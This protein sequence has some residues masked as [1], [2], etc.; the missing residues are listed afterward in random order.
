MIKI[1]HNVRNKNDEYTRCYTEIIHIDRLRD[2]TYTV[3]EQGRAFL[4]IT[5]IDGYTFRYMPVTFEQLT[6]VVITSDLLATN[7]VIFH[8]P[9]VTDREYQTQYF[10]TSNKIIEQIFCLIR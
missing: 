6:E 10:N 5:T 3:N 2:F 1:Q 9:S 4:S 8:I 7:R